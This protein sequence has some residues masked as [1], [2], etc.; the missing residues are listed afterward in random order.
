MRSRRAASDCMVCVGI[1]S[2]RLKM[3]SDTAQRDPARTR[4]CLPTSVSL[5]GWDLSEYSTSQRSGAGALGIAQQTQRSAR[6]QEASPFSLEYTSRAAAVHSYW[7]QIEAVGDTA[8]QRQLTSRSRRPSTVTNWYEERT[9]RRSAYT[10]RE[11]R[12]EWQHAPPGR[13]P[14][15]PSPTGGPGSRS[16]H[17]LPLSSR[18]TPHPPGTMACR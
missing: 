7:M 17:H 13:A 18:E 8:Q 16:R 5:S 9:A 15:P 14:A 2:S 1:H 12:F 3:L 10:T 6:G 11:T 4:T